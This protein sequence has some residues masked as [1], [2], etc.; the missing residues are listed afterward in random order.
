MIRTRQ[1]PLLILAILPIALLA[2]PT[3]SLMAQATDEE[4]TSAANML[5]SAPAPGTTTASITIGAQIKDGRTETQGY[6][7]DAIWAHSTEGR[8]LIRFDGHFTRAEFRPAPGADRIKVDDGHLFSVTA[9]KPLTNSLALTAVG[10]WKRDVPLQLDHRVMAQAG[11]ALNLHRGR[12]LLFTV[13]PTVGVGTQNNVQSTS[14]QGIFNLGG[15]QSLSWQV[16]PTFGLENTFSAYQDLDNSDDHSVAFTLSGTAM[17][18]KHV[19]LKV[20]YKLT[21]EGIHPDDA[22]ARQQELQVGVTITLAGG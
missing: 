16:T 4:P 1:P 15:I 20:S 8:T 13:G 14:S 22:D 9:V 11:V 6:S 17:V 3:G 7:L 21:D 12:T 5:A 19:G 18:A 10:S 2:L